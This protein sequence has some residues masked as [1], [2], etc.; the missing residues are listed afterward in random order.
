MAFS[1]GL[2]KSPKTYICEYCGS[3][4]GYYLCPDGQGTYYEIKDLCKC[5]KARQEAKLRVLRKQNDTKGYGHAVGIS[6]RYEGLKLDDKVKE[7]LQS[8]VIRQGVGCWINGKQSTGKTKNANLI[9]KQCSKNGMSVIL[10]TEIE[11]LNDIKNSYN[12]NQPS[13][14]IIEMFTGC[15]VLII[16][17]LGKGK[18]SDWSIS[19]LFNIINQRYNSVKP[20]C[21]TTD[22]TEEE[23][24]SRW[25]T[26]G[27]EINGNAIL[28]R[29]KDSTSVIDL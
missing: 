8:G 29:L 10:K 25:A 1:L 24:K 20:T 6:Q 16:D 2:E 19:E 15:D 13:Q 4:V 23:L 28:R 3:E 18:P 7:Y 5:R 11:I 12:K 9:A 17:D 26:S 27:E 22:R 21:I 14:E